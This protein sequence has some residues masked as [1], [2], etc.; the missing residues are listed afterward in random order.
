M[1][2]RRVLVVDDS[3]TFRRLAAAAINGLDGYEV[4]GCAGDGLEA[5]QFLAH[6]NVDLV[7]LDLEMPHVNGIAC[8][9]AMRQSGVKARVLVFSAMSHKG[10]HAALAAISGGADEFIAKPSVVAPGRPAQEAIREAL[11]SKLMQFWSP[12]DALS[13]I[14]TIGA[15]RSATPTL[16]TAHWR[17]FNAQG[18]VIAASTGGP[19]ALERLFSA[20]LVPFQCPI[21]V[22]QHMPPV[23]TASLAQRLATHC[24]RVVREACHEETPRAGV[25]YVCPGDFHMRVSRAR[26]GTVKITLDQRPLRNFV[27]PAADYL[28]ESAA[29]AYGRR[30]LGIVLTGMGADGRDGALAIKKAAGA[31]AI[32]DQNTCSVFGMP[33]AVYDAGAS[34]FV[35]SPEELAC[36]IGAA[37]G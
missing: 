19:V 35:G 4:V 22:V 11:A 23:F 21:F 9:V 37:A 31:V 14:T 18:V 1:A 16:P 8:V 6:T 29:Q 2:K 10:A 7:I 25:T 33:K 5:L 13:G 27:R 24:G 34:D 3:P 32:Q 17:Q 26:D 20:T 15:Q 12:D 30:C 28:F 36:I